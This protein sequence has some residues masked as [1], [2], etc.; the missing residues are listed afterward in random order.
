M[1]FKAK[2]MDEAQMRRAV[3]RMSHDIIEQNRDVENLV[4]MGVQARGMALAKQI[5]KI[6]A[7]V[8][9]KEFPV[10]FLDITGNI[11][12]NP[13]VNL[14]F[15]DANVI[16]VDDV[17]HTGRSVRA[18]LDVLAKAG[19]PKTVRLAAL[20][21]RGVRNVAMEPQFTGKAL[22]PEKDEL[23]SVSVLEV[24]GRDGVEIYSMND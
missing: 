4:L 23:V 17:L 3:I 21:D 5:A 12:I 14:A 15:K 11:P 22:S 18:A 13:G 1:T 20:I 19:G 8:E 16:L 6:M 2:I 7:A 9:E 10:F 24:D